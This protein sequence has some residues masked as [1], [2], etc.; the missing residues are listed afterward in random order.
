MVDS[1]RIKEIHACLGAGEA[2]YYNEQGTPKEVV[3][4][5]ARKLD[6]LCKWQGLSVKMNGQYNRSQSSKYFP[7][8][9]PIPPGWYYDRTGVNAGFH[10][11]S[12]MFKEATAPLSIDDQRVGIAYQ[13]RSNLGIESEDGLEIVKGGTVL[14]NNI[15][16]Y[17]D[18]IVD[19][20]AKGLDLEELGTGAITVGDKVFI[21]EGILD[22]LQEIL[23]LVSD[24]NNNTE[25][26]KIAIG[27]TQQVSKE[28]LKALGLPYGVKAFEYAIEG[29]G[30]DDMVEGKP[31]KRKSVSV[32]Y[33]ATL[34]GAPTLTDILLAILANQGIANISQLN[35]KDSKLAEL[36]N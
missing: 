28:I 10:E 33:P 15:L 9:R 26:S 29:Q 34:Y 32:P 7:P 4:N 21:Y 25:E 30:V 23:F 11:D 20:F 27:V 36:V 16:Q 22:I 35:L 1:I 5:I 31:L 6:L 14:C 3:M 24:N 19:D 17:L 8:G 13:V 12:E 2:S 18:T